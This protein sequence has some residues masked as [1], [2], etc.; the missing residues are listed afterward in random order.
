MNRVI[1]HI[2]SHRDKLRKSEKLVADWI[3]NHPNDAASFSIGMLAKTVG[4]SEPTVI[5]FCRAIGFDGYHVFKQ[6]LAE[7]LNAGVPFIHSNVSESDNTKDI[8]N[9]VITQASAA[10]LRTKESLSVKAVEQAVKI[11]LRSSNVLCIGHGAS[12]VVA[13]DIQQKL[14]RVGINV[15]VFSDHHVHSLAASLMGKKEVLIAVSHTGRSQDILDSVSFAKANGASVISFTTKDS[16]LAEASDVVLE[17]GATEDTTEYIP[18]IS[19]LADLAIV[20]VLLVILALKRGNSFID[21]MSRSKAII[22][23]KRVRNSQQQN[24]G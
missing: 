11:L 3:M 7:S 21:E 6:E 20:D 14:L 15:S 19:R 17:S 9:K 22:E 18:M 12:N 5:R 8:V 10:L 2:R 1:S 24:N 13:L 23:S 4:V 16:P